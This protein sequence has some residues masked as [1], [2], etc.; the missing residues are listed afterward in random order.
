MF[1]GEE[2][3]VAKLVKKFSIFHETSMLTACSRLFR[4]SVFSTVNDNFMSSAE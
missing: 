4:V 1:R 2:L 3:V